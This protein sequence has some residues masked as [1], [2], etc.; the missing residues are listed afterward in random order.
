MIKFFLS[1]MSISV[2]LLIC[3][4]ICWIGKSIFDNW[5]ELPSYILRNTFHIPIEAYCYWRD[6]SISAFIIGTFWYI[7]LISITVILTYLLVRLIK[8]IHNDG[9]Y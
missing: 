8:G 3:S 2:Y 1:S 7:L 5:K 9:E 6:V 4:G